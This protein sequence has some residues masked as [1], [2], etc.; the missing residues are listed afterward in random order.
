VNGQYL[1]AAL[2]FVAAALLIGYCWWLDCH[3]PKEKT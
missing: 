2:P 1:W 3:P